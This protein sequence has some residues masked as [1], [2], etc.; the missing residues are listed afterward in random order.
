MGQ[1][2]FDAVKIAVPEWGFRRDSVSGIIVYIA[3]CINSSLV[4]DRGLGQL[5]PTQHL[6]LFFLK[7]LFFFG[8]YRIIIW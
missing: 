2:H 6:G 7:L 3:F 8:G 5:R 4:L 1:R